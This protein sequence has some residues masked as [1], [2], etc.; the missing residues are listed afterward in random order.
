MSLVDEFPL[1]QIMQSENE[2]MKYINEIWEDLKVE[3]GKNYLQ[4]EKFQK[5][6]EIMR[7]L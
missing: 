2:V 5:V 4:L 6:E 3:N 1:I 7:Q